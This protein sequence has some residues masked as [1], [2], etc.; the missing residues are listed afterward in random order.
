MYEGTSALPL[1]RPVIRPR[2]PRETARP[3]P[4]TVTA[5]RERV[6]A[7]PV[8]RTG[9]RVA[10]RPAMK[11]SFRTVALFICAMALLL[12]I[13]YS[14]MELS[15]LNRAYLQNAKFLQD[16]KKDESELTRKVEAGVSLSEVEAYAVGEL[17]MVKPSRDQI[18][19]INLA[20][21]DHAEIIPQK[22]FWGAVK[23]LFGTMSTKVI[24][25]ID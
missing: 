5:P 1:E 10:E 24:E 23:Q 15:Q 8:T 4:R 11:L 9:A 18:V 25:F 22:G 16:L 6:Q 7:R 20:G 3:A 13:V 2:L 21:E 19:Y 14:Y 12:F 17:G